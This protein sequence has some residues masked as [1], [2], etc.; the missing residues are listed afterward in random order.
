MSYLLIQHS[1]ED[2]NRWKAAFDGDKAHRKSAGSKGGTIL[3]NA[4][5]PNQITVLFKWDNIQHEREFA[6][7]DDLH[8]T[9]EGAGVIGKPNVFFL[10]EAFDT[11][12]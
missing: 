7:S 12:E 9:M 8:K 5:N 10:N 3:R 1:V 6:N 11:S 2:Y 4:D